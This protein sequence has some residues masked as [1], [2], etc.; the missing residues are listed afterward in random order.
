MGGG[1]LR[2]WLREL[3]EPTQVLAFGS[4]YEPQ[5]RAT[6]TIPDRKEARDAKPKSKPSNRE[7]PTEQH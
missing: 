7:L 5:A 2:E 4:P 1:G 6:Q 3:P